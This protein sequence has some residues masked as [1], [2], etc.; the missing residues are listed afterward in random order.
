[1]KT[2]TTVSY[3]IFRELRRSA[4]AY[5]DP[6]LIIHCNAEVAA[7]LQGEERQELRHLMDRFNKSIQLKVQPN[8][9]REQY[10]IYAK[11][12]AGNEYK[13]A[14]SSETFE[15]TDYG[16]PKRK[17]GEQREGGGRDRDRDRG[18]GGRDRDRG[19]GKDRGRDRDKD[20]ER[21]RPSAPGGEGSKPSQSSEPTAGGN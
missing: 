11:P 7:M 4:G 8:F 21:P 15:P 9:H 18:R 17:E 19:R 6:T 10:D 1:V 3:E 13:V 14:S 2:T 20:R 16:A 5:R 12:M